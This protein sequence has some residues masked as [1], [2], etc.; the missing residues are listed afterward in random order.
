MVKCEIAKMSFTDKFIMIEISKEFLK[1]LGQ[2]ILKFI[3]SHEDKKS[4]GK[5][6]V[7]MKL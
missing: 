7:F 4:E 5:V 6:T 1:N 3:C 2:D